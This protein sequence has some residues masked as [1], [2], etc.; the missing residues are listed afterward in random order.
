MNMGKSENTSI[1]SQEQID[2]IIHQNNGEF[3][4]QVNRNYVPKD[5]YKNLKIKSI[6][7][8]LKMKLVTVNPLVNGIM[9]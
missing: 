4:F 1:I 9:A 7:K 5:H 8:N 6:I 3:P 2:E